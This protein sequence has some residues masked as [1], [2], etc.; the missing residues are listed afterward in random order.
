MISRLFVDTNILVYSRD[1]ASPFFTSVRDAL[2]GLVGAGVDLCIHRQVLRE[3]MSV[4]TRPYP[5]GLGATPQKALAEVAEFESFYRVLLEPE[6]VWETWKQIVQETGLTG[7]R[8]HDAY[9]AAV[10]IGHRIQTIMTMNTADFETIS[11]VSVV[12]PQNWQ[13]L[14]EPGEE[15]A[16]EPPA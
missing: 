7:L 1:E 5:R 11:G 4:A 12:E 15:Q 13:V 3:Y 10:M 6:N 9:L 16:D 14:I 2:R 8:V